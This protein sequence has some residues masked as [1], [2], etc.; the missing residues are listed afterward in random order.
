LA[1]GKQQQRQNAHDAATGFQGS[2]LFYDTEM[3]GGFVVRPWEQERYVS[4]LERIDFES[5]D[6]TQSVKELLRLRERLIT[7][8]LS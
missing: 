6:A 5:M 7:V 1:D 3:T 8:G 4:F 2:K